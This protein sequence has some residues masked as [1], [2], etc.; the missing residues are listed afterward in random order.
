VWELL[1]LKEVDSGEEKEDER[2]NSGAVDTVWLVS[3]LFSI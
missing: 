3:S 2:A 1:Y